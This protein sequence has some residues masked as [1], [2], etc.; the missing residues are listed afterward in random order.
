[1]DNFQPFYVFNKRRM[2]DLKVGAAMIKEALDREL[3]KE[4]RAAHKRA[5]E[6]AAHEAAV[7]KVSCTGPMGG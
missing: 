3:P 1:M 4:E 2:N 7:A 5:E 6:K